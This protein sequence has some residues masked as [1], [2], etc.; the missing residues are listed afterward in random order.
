MSK[1]YDVISRLE[2]ASVQG[3]NGFDTVFP[4]SYQKPEQ[5]Q[6]PWIRILVFAVAFVA[7]GGLTVVFTGWWQDRFSQQGLPVF[8]SRPVAVA[9]TP[10]TVVPVT[11]LLIEAHPATVT[12]TENRETDQNSVTDTGDISP[13]TMSVDVAETAATVETI[14]RILQTTSLN[15]PAPNKPTSSQNT[16]I[17]IRE[18]DIA[19]AEPYQDQD[20]AP[21]DQTNSTAEYTKIGDDKAKTSRWLHQAELYRRSGEWEGA[22]LLYQ[23][24]WDITGDPGV[25]NNLAASLIEM[26]RFEEALK[27]LKESSAI[28]PNDPDIKM[29]LSIVKRILDRH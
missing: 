21:Q 14:D 11:N 25:A 29:N 10:T 3:G 20:Q 8:S 1:L 5:E 18:L 23:R 15:T 26:K 7:L 13:E 19:E 16:T 12:F 28:A 27:I 4:D 24:V 2:D 22:I 9:E 17:Y 6:A